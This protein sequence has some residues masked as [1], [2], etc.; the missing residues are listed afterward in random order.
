MDPVCLPSCASS[1]DY[2]QSVLAEVTSHILQSALRFVISR[3]CT[4]LT[5]SRA[6]PKTANALLLSSDQMLCN[7]RKQMEIDRAD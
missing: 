1:C 7:L 2:K 5:S 3:R 6:H 4:Q